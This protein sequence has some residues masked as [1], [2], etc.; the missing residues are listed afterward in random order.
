MPQ[1][2]HAP[3]DVAAPRVRSVRQVF[4]GG[5]PG[6]GRQWFSWVH[7]DDC[8]SAAVRAL[9]DDGLSGPVNVTAPRPVRMQE[10]CRALGAAMGRPSWLPVPEFAIQALLG[11]GAKVVVEGQQARC[12]VPSVSLRFPSLPSFA[13]AH[14]PRLRARGA[15]GGSIR[16]PPWAPCP[17][18]RQVMPARLQAAGFEWRYLSIEEA[19]R[20]VVAQPR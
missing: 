12:V 18:V 9:A 19:L 11:D 17:R 7:M 14:A 4:A 2:Q 6:D 20:S 13:R 3:T 16:G 10:M 15:D 5:A 8:V 1:P